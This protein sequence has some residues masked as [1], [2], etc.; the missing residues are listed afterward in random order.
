MVGRRTAQR[1]QA[2]GPPG[3]LYTLP[4]SRGLCGPQ[5]V[6]RSAGQVRAARPRVL[7][8]GSPRCPASGHRGSRPQ[9]H[10]GRHAGGGPAA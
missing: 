10:R 1:T 5:H 3:P 9:P 7:P 4:R 6:R 2:T 8:R